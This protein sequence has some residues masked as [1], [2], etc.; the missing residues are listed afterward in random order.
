MICPNCQKEINDDSVFCSYCATPVQLDESSLSDSSGWAGEYRSR[1]WVYGKC[2]NIS[3]DEQTKLRIY[4]FSVIGENLFFSLSE[5]AFQKTNTRVPQRGEGIWTQITDDG[6]KRDNGL[7]RCFIPPKVPWQSD[8]KKFR[9][10]YGVGDVLYAPISEIQENAIWLEL[11]GNGFR[12]KISFP[13]F[14]LEKEYIMSNGSGYVLIRVD[15]YV[16]EKYQ[17]QCSIVHVNPSPL[18]SR[19]PESFSEEDTNSW[20]KA[21]VIAEY[22]YPGKTLSEFTE[23]I[24]SLYRENYIKR[25]IFIGRK[26]GSET[27]LISF[28]VDG[29]RSENKIPVDVRLKWNFT[30]KKMSFESMGPTQ[31]EFALGRDVFIPSWE[32]MLNELKEMALEEDWDYGNGDR[33]ELK[34]LKNYLLFAYYK[35]KLEGKVVENSYGEAIFNTGLVDDQYDDIYCYLEKNTSADFHER[36]YQFAFFACKG[37]GAGKGKKLIERFP[38]SVFPAPPSYLHKNNLE[39]LYY[40][41]DFPIDT[42]YSHIIHDNI[43][44]IPFEFIKSRIGSAD[45]E[46][47]ALIREYEEASTKAKKSC[48]KALYEKIKNKPELIRYLQYGLEEAVDTA[49]KYCRW[50]Y[51]TAIPVYYAKKD[52]IS[53]LLPL[54]LN[55]GSRPADIALVVERLKNGNY[56]GQTIYTM[57]MAYND[58]RQICRPNSDWLIANQI[59]QDQVDD[60]FATG[61]E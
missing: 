11:S 10:K 29:C 26:T 40:N 45:A 27:L 39:E 16:P 35:S 23:I 31:P 61:E 15:K 32:K 53:L 9:K 44:R 4:H 1:D 57:E 51:K 5:K 37:K 7:L 22:Y 48:L 36:P 42:D 14:S 59:V 2:N 34:I 52:C 41:P 47:S 17:V 19:L 58:A 8:Y 24:A 54:K 33:K 60:D 28:L 21:R 13:P 20:A 55:T 12:T 38:S 6:V 18:W 43:E 30:K 3:E 25:S 56:Q 50:N 49:K 46:V